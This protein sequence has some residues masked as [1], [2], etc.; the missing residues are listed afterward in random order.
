MSRIQEIQ[1]TNKSQLM[2]AF[3]CADDS[4]ADT[5]ITLKGISTTY[6]I[7]KFSDTKKLRGKLRR[8]PA[9]VFKSN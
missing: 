2:A 8:T 1:V 7:N 9:S 4:P 5:L 3:W 6:F